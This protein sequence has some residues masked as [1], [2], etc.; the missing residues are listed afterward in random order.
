MAGPFTHF[1]IV[2]SAKRRRTVIGSLLYR[3]LNKHSE[4]LYLGA[5]SPDLPY[6]SF[7]TGAVNWADLMHYENTNGIVLYGYDEIRKNWSADRMSE[8]GER[9]LAWLFGYA[10]HLIVDATIHPIVEAI[11]GLYKDNSTEHRICE[12]T[13]DSLVYYQRKNA[14]IRYT[15]F[16]SIIKY[17]GESEHDFETLVD[18][19]QK[20]TVKTYPAAAEDPTPA[21]WFKT[22]S[23]AI[24]AAEGGSRVVALFRHAGVGEDFIYKTQE[25]IVKQ[26]FRDQ[27]KYYTTVK[28]PG[29]GTGSFSTAGV[30]RAVENVANAWR[31]LYEGFESGVAIERVVRNWNLDTGAEIGGTDGIKTYWT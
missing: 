3:L 27:E 25:E 8:T 14:E 12:M 28:L 19:W 2:D 22:Y 15:E 23:A 13:Q 24:D 21:L 9:I 16:S 6:L 29:G 5:V 26:H 1:L 17:C 18:F 10:S 30:N 4:F 7:K 31:Q 20:Q 11:V